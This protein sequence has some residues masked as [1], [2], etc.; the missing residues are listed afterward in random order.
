MKCQILSWKFSFAMKADMNCVDI[1]MG[2]TK[3]YGVVDFMAT[4]P[5]ERGNA[6]LME[7]TCEGSYSFLG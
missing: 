2:H 1:A 3:M 4:M 6:R 5:E 7:S